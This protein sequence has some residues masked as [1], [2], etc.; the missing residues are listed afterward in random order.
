YQGI[1][2]RPK[3]R[4]AAVVGTK[5]LDVNHAPLAA[6]RTVN[7]IASDQH[8]AGMGDAAF[9]E[10]RDA[11]T[12]LAEAHI[13][14]AQIAGLTVFTTGSPADALGAVRDA[15]IAAPPVPSKPF[16]KNEVFDDY[17]VYESTIPMPE[18]QEGAP[19]YTDAGGDWVFDAMGIPV[20][21]RQEEA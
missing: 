16:V 18:Y 8:P 4:Y 14:R 17:C 19:P 12:A 7:Q 13:D 5:I 1:P 2:L 15:M 21:Q 10:H 20:L 3:T 9:A 6:S 11:L